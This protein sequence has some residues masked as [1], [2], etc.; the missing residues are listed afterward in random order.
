VS[1]TP[2]SD[3]APVWLE[4]RAFTLDEL[5]ARFVEAVERGGPPRILEPDAD[6]VALRQE[7]RA[8]RAKLA[9]LEEMAREI[10]QSSSYSDY[11]DGRWE[12]A[13]RI[14]DVVLDDNR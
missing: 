2:D 7:L 4:A 12:M 10:H 9:T 6:V 1:E 5:R 3:S 11:G 13:R 14:L 8:A